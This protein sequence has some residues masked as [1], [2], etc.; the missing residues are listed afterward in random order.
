[1]QQY[2]VS[3]NGDV[4]LS[5]DRVRLQRV[6]GSLGTTYARV[7][8]TIG[9]LTRGQPAYSLS[10]EIPAGDVAATLHALGYPSYLTRGTF[11]ARLHIGGAGSQPNVA[12]HVEAPAGDVNGLPFVD[13]RALLSADSSGVRA[14]DGSVRI[15]STSARFDAATG[16]RY[17]AV[18][19]DAPSANLSDFNN[20]FDA[21]DMFRGRGSVALDANSPARGCAVAGKWRSTDWRGA[22]CRSAQRGPTG[23]AHA[24]R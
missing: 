24:T 1:M 10:A 19:V 8:G 21:G 6:I 7:D 5:G 22:I 12:G 16:K 18:S 3:G 20:F 15:G 9:S 17:T 14:R 11:N 2:A 4:A 13:A 23:R